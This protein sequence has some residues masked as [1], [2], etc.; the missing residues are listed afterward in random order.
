MSESRMF[1]DLEQQFSFA[2]ECLQF[3]LSLHV[4]VGDSLKL[5]DLQSKSP[6]VWRG[7]THQDVRAERSK[8]LLGRGHGLC[9]CTQCS[10]GVIGSLSLVTADKDENMVVFP[11]PWDLRLGRRGMSSLCGGPLLGRAS[12]SLSTCLE[13]ALVFLLLLSLIQP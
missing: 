10:F 7:K 1:C 13:T 2:L 3:Q 12:A 4:P 5:N 8:A 6:P 9:L 11:R